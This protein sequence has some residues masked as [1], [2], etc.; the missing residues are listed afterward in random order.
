MMGTRAGTRLLGLASAGWAVALLTG[1]RQWW[2]SLTGRP[3]TAT[4]R[5]TVVVLAGRQFVQG[6]AQ[7]V[8]PDRLRWTW[9][10]VDLAHAG[11]MVLLA[12]R[13]PSD[14]RPALVSAGVAAASAAAALA[15]M[16]S[17]R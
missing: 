7:L 8:V 14:R 17:A 16:R 11:S 13:R 5:A 4:E 3:P 15:V 6:L 10:A 9:L 12:E 1:G 2:T